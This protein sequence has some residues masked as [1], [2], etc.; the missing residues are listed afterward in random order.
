MSRA[1]ADRI[2]LLFIA[3]CWVAGALNLADAFFRPADLTREHVVLA[4]LTVLGLGGCAAWS[5]A[6]RYGQM[7]V[8]AAAAAY[9]VLYSQR[10][11]TVYIE[12]ELAFT[13]VSF[14][15]AVLDK[16]Q[17]VHASIAHSLSLGNFGNG[18]SELFSEWLMPLSQLAALVETA[19][20]LVQ[21]AR[22]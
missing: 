16:F 12:P 20:G 3:A 21:R 1:H 2:V 9:V 22:N 7:A 15:E 11:W 10:M 4:A 13:G 8:A 5:A 19:L 18:L 17:V 14:F 6:W